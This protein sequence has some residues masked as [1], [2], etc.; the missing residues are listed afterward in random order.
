[1]SNLESTDTA[2]ETVTDIAA[3]GTVGVRSKRRLPWARCTAV[4]GG[5][6]V[7][8]VAFLAGRHWRIQALTAECKNAVDRNDWQQLEVSAHQLR[9][10]QPERAVP[11]IYLAEAANQQGRLEEAV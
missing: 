1:M 11:L 3:D 6:V 7:L 5:L 8:A 10:W 2:T 9:F 4:F